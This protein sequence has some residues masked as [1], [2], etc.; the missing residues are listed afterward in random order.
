MDQRIIELE[1]TTQGLDAQALLAEAVKIFGGKIALASSFSIE[2]QVITHMLLKLSDDVE[3]F[4]LDTGRLPQET[5]DVIDLTRKKYG[6][7]IEMLTPDS[8][9]LTEMLNEHGPNLFYESIDNRR[10]CCHV[11]KVAPLKKKLAQLDAWICGLRSDQS[12]TRG[13]L[14]RIDW[15]SSNELVKILPLADWRLEQTWEYIRTNDIPYNKLHDMN[16]PSIGCVP[17]TRAVKDGEDIRAGRWW[18]EQPEHK[19]CGLHLKSKIKD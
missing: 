15:D 12:V 18:W 19:E 11:R 10:L 13:D 7:T 1:K 14:K 3:I 4:T 6:V 5:Y 2:D 9:Q 8:A 17:C 16:Y